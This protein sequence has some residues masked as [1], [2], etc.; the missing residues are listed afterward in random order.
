MRILYQIFLGS[1]SY[2][3]LVNGMDVTYNI[4]ILPK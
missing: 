1:I 4:M 3:S 2:E